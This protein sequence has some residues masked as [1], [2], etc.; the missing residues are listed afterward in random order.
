MAAF[1]VPKRT[2]S[3]R[4]VSAQAVSPSAA[5]GG[6]YDRRDSEFAKLATLTQTGRSTATTVLAEAVVA[7]LSKDPHIEADSRKALS[8]TD[9]RQDASL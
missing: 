8:F 5:W 7:G 6:A 9:N 3:C 4:L 1:R 2:V